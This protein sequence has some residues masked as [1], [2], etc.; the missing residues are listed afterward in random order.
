[1]YPQRSEVIMSEALSTPRVSSSEDSIVLEIIQ[2]V[3][4]EADVDPVDLPPL[5]DYIDPDIFDD[6]ASSG[7]HPLRTYKI[8]FEY[9]GHVVSVDNDGTVTV[10]ERQY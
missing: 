3:A 10:D 8:V 5:Y 7:D 2:T 1:M 6:R 4:R 9:A